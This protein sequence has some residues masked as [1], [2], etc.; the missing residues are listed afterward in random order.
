MARLGPLLQNVLG[1]IDRAEPSRRGLEMLAVAARVGDREGA[2]GRLPLVLQL[3][4][5]RPHAG[6][7]WPEYRQRVG[8]ELQLLNAAVCADEATPLA[9]AG[10]LAVHL[11]P[12]QARAMAGVDAFE[13]VEL[14]PVFVP[15]AM[16][17]AVGDVGLPSFRGRH[18]GL[19]GDGVRVAVLDSGI[20]TAHPFLRVHESVETCGESWLIPGRHGT[21]CAG[22]IASLDPVFP[23]IAPDVT[24]LNVKVLDAS[25]R[26]PHTDVVKG[27]ERALDLQADILSVSL[28]F[29]HLPTWSDRGHGWACAD[30]R[31]P[32]CLAVDNTVSFGAFVCVA[33][34]NEHARA[35]ALRGI[36]HGG[37]FDTELGC[38]GQA[39]GAFTVGA[40]TKRTFLAADFSSRGPTAYG[41]SKPDLAAPGVNVTSTAPVPRLPDGSLTSQPQRGELFARMSGTSMATPIVAGAAALVVE[42]LRQQGSAVTPATIAQ[43]LRTSAAAPMAAMPAHV[44]G[45]GRLDLT[46]T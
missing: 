40:L 20:D 5:R 41:L 34:G 13:T 35:E 30:G 8:G 2:D 9:L 21:H 12:E 29:N 16:D 27:M 37:S 26:G 36:G 17:D 11:P 24:L 7:T 22:S 14:D 3:P 18:A 38:P 32:L 42:M 44:V 25:G 1:R 15:T 10:A 31:C 23:G 39:R 33:A 19:T 6:E 43:V 45:A 46:L 4:D 28:A